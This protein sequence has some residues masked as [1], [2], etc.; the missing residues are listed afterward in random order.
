LEIIIES[1]LAAVKDLSGRG[2]HF[3]DLSRSKTQ[4]LSLNHSFT[5]FAISDIHS[6]SV[7]LKESEDHEN[8]R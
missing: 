6:V 5:P 7:S 2:V 8:H 3:S 4:L 1:S